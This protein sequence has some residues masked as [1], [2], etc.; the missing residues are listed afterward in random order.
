MGAPIKN[1]NTKS[2][3]FTD[4]IDAFHTT[5]KTG[6]VTSTT[7]PIF[8]IQ[9]GLT[10]NLQ[11]TQ[12]HMAQPS[13]IN[14]SYFDC[15]GFLILSNFGKDVRSKIKYKNEISWNELKY[16]MHM[17]LALGRVNC[18]S[19]FYMKINIFVCGHNINPLQ[20]GD[21]IHIISCEI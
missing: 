11:H 13:S 4:L 10:V 1:M 8:Q 17:A 3:P 16:S 5:I 18:R 12:H 15:N 9:L 2:L 19:I 20:H 14:Y 6:C 21:T 7:L